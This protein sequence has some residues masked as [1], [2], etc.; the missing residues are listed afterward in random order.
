MREIAQA[1]GSGRL[2]ASGA[3]LRGKGHVT[4]RRA[5]L[6]TVVAAATIAMLVVMGTSV[7]MAAEDTEPPV[8]LG[9][10]LE[11]VSVNTSS[12]AQTV[13]ATAHITDN[14][15][16][17][18]EVVVVARSPS[19]E[20]TVVA[21]FSRVSGTETDG[22]YQAALEIPRF[23]ESGAWHIAYVSL[24][25]HAGNFTTVTQS[26]LE[27]KELPAT[28]QVESVVDTEPPVLLGFGLEPVSVNTSSAAQ[29]VTAT[30]HITDNLSGVSEVVVVARSPSKEQTVVASFSR[31]SGT[32]TDGVYQ[33]ALE[34]PRF[35]ESGAWHIA[36]VSLRD[37]AGNFTTVT[38]SE[39]ESKELPATIQVGGAP[40]KASIMF[41]ASGS[42]Y[43][44]GAVV[45]TRFLCTEGEGGPGIESCTDSNGGSGTSG[46]LDTSTLGA[47]TY[48]VTAKSRDGE[49]GTATI[50][51]TVVKA[52]CTT[53]TGTVRLS[54]GLTDT[55]AV[56]TIEIKGALTGCTGE[57]FAEVSYKATL[58]TTGP[59]SCSVLA[60][61]SE[62]ATGSAKYEWTPKSKPSTAGRLSLVLS[63]TP[64]VAFFGET[65]AGSFSPL[66]FAGS[67]TETYEGGSKCGMSQ[68]K[69]AAKPVKQGNFTGT[70]VAFR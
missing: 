1:D 12:A 65:T 52:T 11:P 47:H 40:P 63:E 24:R 23:A 5:L 49:T 19:K 25:D 26:E 44:R 41:P 69:N 20:Q 53:N 6:M 48:T 29:T 50:S 64:S 34:I 21:S 18:S 60:G 66:T 45:A 57:P 30:A 70:T 55:P 59:V 4:T 9:F 33:A 17:V 14:L 15:S 42:I 10:G 46:V 16:G 22:V 32:E 54:P 68:G 31:V 39:L 67:V 13:T 2:W 51:Y 56:Q 58:T 3:S 8:L 38:Q 27:S 61:P 7:A 62:S 36:Y 43:L 37:H 28:I 35:A